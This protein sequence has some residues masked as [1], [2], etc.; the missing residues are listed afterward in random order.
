M[1][2]D[3]RDDPSVKSVLIDTVG[4]RVGPHEM[5]GRKNAVN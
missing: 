4:D 5:I 3:E 2:N 1:G